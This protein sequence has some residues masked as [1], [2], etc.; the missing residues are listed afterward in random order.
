MAEPFVGEIRL[1]AFGV[2]PR[3]WAP[4]EGQ[5]LPVAQNQALFAILG[6]QYG[7]D[8]RVNFALPNLCGRVPLHRD[9]TSIPQ[10]RA[11]G[12]ETHTLTIAEMPRHV[13]QVFGSGADGTTQQ[14][15]GNTWAKSATNLYSSGADVVLSTAAITSEGASQGHPNMQPYLV[16]NYCIALI[17]I[18]PPRN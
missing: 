17:G 10:G 7:G 2:V 4:C 9:P 1:F 13:H 15:P 6:T 11:Q 3:G 16:A 5:L 18:F 8:G 14:A 12:E